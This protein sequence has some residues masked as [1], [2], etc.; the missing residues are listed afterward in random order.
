MD[1][2]FSKLSFRGAL[3]TKNL[4]Y[5]HVYVH[6]ILRFALNDIYSFYSF[7]CF[8]ARLL[9]TI[10]NTN[11]VTKMMVDNGRSSGVKPPLRAS[12]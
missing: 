8:S 7:C 1:S 10:S 9:I 12:A 6:E 11:T 3:A 4:E 5:I 2:Y